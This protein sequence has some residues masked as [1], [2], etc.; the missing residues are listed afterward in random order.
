MPLLVFAVAVGGALATFAD[1]ALGAAP[2]PA[3]ASRAVAMVFAG[4]P[5]AA[6]GDVNADGRA[7]AADVSGV[8]LGLRSPTQPGPYGV[9]LRRITFTKRSETMPEQNRPL[10]TDIWYPAPPGAGPIDRR[11]GGKSNAP[12]AE[13]LSN[14]PLVLFS[15]GSCGFQEQSIFFTSTL[16][17]YGFVVAAPPHPGNSTAEILTCGTPAAVADSFANRPA[18]IMFV[19]DSLLALNAD[20]TSF[21]FGTID[22]DRIGVSGH[23]FGGLTTLRVSAMDPRVSA[24]LA[25]APVARSIQDEVAQIAVP[26][27]IQVGTLDGLLAD[28]RLAYDL[29]KAPRYRLEILRT[30]HSPFSDFCLECTPNTT[31]TEQAHLYSLRYSIPYLLHYVVGDGRFDAFLAPHAAPPGVV[32]TADVAAEELSH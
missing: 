1:A 29:L 7:G 28:A 10:L 9:G 15:H 23:S 13:E 6:G 21:F 30:T 18:D 17:S 22:P 3:E 16:A 31:T 27:M 12:L 32:L 24:G 25:L 2:T 5:G 11:P 19:I 8:M 20:P 4:D 26:I 14:L